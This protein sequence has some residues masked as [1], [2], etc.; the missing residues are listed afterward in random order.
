MPDVLKDGDTQNLSSSHSWEP[1]FRRSR[2]FTRGWTLQELIAPSV[3][4]FYSSNG[5]LLGT[6]QSLEL[7]VHEITGIAISALQG[8]P[9]SK[10]HFDERMSWA[11]NRETK[12][13]EDKAYSLLGIFDVHMP[14]IY[15]EG[16]KNAS[17]RLRE[18]FWR[19][20][21]NAQ[22]DG[23]STVPQAR[24]I[25]AKRL[26]STFNSS[27]TISPHRDADSMDLEMPLQPE[28]SNYDG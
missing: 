19:R 21:S 23:P 13:E 11:E 10:F 15:G 9:L 5:R 24:W 17:Q 8:A 6:K 26:T 3:V 20:S 22:L 1:A 2:W 7:Q 28:T 25:A 12:R 4:E 27:S 16:A 14:L 18:E